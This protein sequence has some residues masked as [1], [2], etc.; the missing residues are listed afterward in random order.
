MQMSF[1]QIRTDTEEE[2][3]EEEEQKEEEEEEEEEQKEEEEEEE[4]EQSDI[5]DQPEARQCIPAAEL[6]QNKWRLALTRSTKTDSR[7]NH[8]HPW[9]NKLQDAGK[10][11]KNN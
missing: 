11:A 6:Q 4:E 2:E 7:Q 10:K 5:T 3:E 8:K 9:K 1:L